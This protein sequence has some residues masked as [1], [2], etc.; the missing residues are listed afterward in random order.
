MTSYRLPKLLIIDARDHIMGRLA[1]TVA[2]HLL[3]GTKIVVLRAE[4][5]VMSGHLIRNKLKMMAFRGHKMNTNP[6]RGPFQYLQPSR[7]F[8][9]VVRG[10]LPHRKP[11]GKR[12]L[13]LFH[14]YDGIPPRFAHVKKVKLV[15]AFRAIKLDPNR[16]FTSLGRLMTC[17][18][19]PHGKL[20]VKLEHKR[21]L[22]LAQTFKIQREIQKLKEQAILNTAKKYL[23]EEHGKKD[24]EWMTQYCFELPTP[25]EV[26]NPPQR[27]EAKLRGMDLKP[28][29]ENKTVSQTQAIPK[30]TDLL[31][32]Q[33][34]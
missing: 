14:C 19:W 23:S 33:G 2:K 28:W 3:M 10:M 25:A 1:S 34:V 22:K 15:T 30:E 32:P 8:Y 9:R 20:M 17:F 4:R 16:P 5:I 11:R 21:R 26:E 7:M 31:P 18:G 24:Y 13:R 12:A 29:D 6:R 27:K